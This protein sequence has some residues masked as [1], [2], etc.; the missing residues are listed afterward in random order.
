MSRPVA[1]TPSREVPAG[2]IAGVFGLQGELKCDPTSAGRIVFS[3]GAALRCEI[4]G[5][6]HEV[7][8][9]G[10]REHK[11]RLL[12][13]LDGV[14]GANAAS[15]YVGATLFA[16]RELIQLADDEYLD[17]D[18]IGCSVYEQGG[19]CLGVVTGIEHYPTSDML[20]VDGHLVPMIKEFVREIDIVARR[21]TVD[22]PPGLFDE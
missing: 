7:R 5:A 2:R 1:T 6:S 15:A 14:T 16:R 18:L 8:V 3:V 10:V 17:R 19:A 22:V 9:A 21:V 20:L 4:G 11:G 13:R 12:I